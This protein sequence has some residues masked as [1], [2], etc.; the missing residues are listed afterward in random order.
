MMRGMN[1]PTSDAL[2]DLVSRLPEYGPEALTLLGDDDFRLLLA[3]VAADADRRLL[4]ASAS[5]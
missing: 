1:L 2:Q 5:R 3:G 4:A